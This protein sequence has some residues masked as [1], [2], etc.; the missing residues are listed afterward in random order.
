MVVVM[1][2]GFRSRFM[3]SPSQEWISL[4]AGKARN[5]EHRIEG[6]AE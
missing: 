6:V 3:V 1:V 2:V 5:R 4:G